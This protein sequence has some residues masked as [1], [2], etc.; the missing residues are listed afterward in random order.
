MAIRLIDTD[1]LELKSFGGG[2][3]PRYAILSH[4]WD[5]DSEITFQEMVAIHADSSHPAAA[6][7]GYRKIQR[8]CGVARARGIRFFWAD[9]CCIDKTS[10]AELSEAINSMYRWYQEAEVCFAILSDFRRLGAEPLETSLGRCRWFRRGWCLQELVAPRAVEFFDAQWAPFG[11]RASLA[12][13]L[14]EITRIPGEL[15]TGTACIPDF[16]IAHIMSWAAGRETT[17]EEDMAYCLMGVFNVHMPIIYGEGANAFVRL[18]HEI[19]KS[20]NDLSIFAFGGRAVDPG[21]ARPRLDCDL[22]A[23]SPD[24]FLGCGDLVHS[25]AHAGFNNNVFALTNQGLHFPQADLEVY[26][27]QG[28][29]CMSLNCTSSNS[30]EGV[31]KMCIRQ[32]G[33]GLFVRCH[34][35]SPQ[36]PYNV[37]G[38]TQPRIDHK[39]DIYILAT[40]DR[41]RRSSLSSAEEYAIE[42]A[43][44]GIDVSRVLQ[45]AVRSLTSNCWDISCLR[46]LTGGDRAFM[47]YWKV[48]P[49]R[50]HGLLYRLEKAG[51]ALD[52]FYLL[53][54]LSGSGPG[55]QPQGWVHL[56][57]AK[58]WRVLEA[59]LGIITTLGDVVEGGNVDLTRSQLTVGG[60]DEHQLRI[61]AV[62]HPWADGPVPKFKLVLNWEF[63]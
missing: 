43:S 13:V 59:R 12:P 17:R 63:T 11:S 56:V 22:F 41:L 35:A 54:G 51:I 23:K 9:T 2:A 3:V 1:T 25:T 16:P 18:Q 48:L 31:I 7:E 29:Y 5:L 52:H 19:I 50:D 57:T 53:C 27:G 39:R 10:S 28:I 14:A 34:P 30:K 42:V 37:A 61:E 60:Q 24:D 33:P 40:Q 49:H 36:N 20:S 4:K 55:S 45:V 62:M 32:V 6:K 8:A 44:H 21:D 15:L 58:D 38:N 46:F 26:I 47:G